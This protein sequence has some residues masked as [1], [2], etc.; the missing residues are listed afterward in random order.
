MASKT[1]R[2]AVQKRWRKLRIQSLYL[3]FGHITISE[4]ISINF[5]YSIVDTWE[6][7]SPQEPVGMAGVHAAIKQ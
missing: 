5:V 2:T 7:Q 3:S 4:K 1:F 6:T